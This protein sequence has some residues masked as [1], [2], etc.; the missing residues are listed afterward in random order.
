MRL[1]R[2]PESTLFRKVVLVKRRA[3][4]S[5]PNS[6]T[7]DNG[8]ETGPLW[9]NR[10]SR[11]GFMGCLG[12]VRRK[13]TIRRVIHLYA[14]RNKTGSPKGPRSQLPGLWVPGA[15]DLHHVLQHPSPNCPVGSPVRRPIGEPVPTA[16]QPPLLASHSRL[17]RSQRRSINAPT[18]LH[19]GTGLAA[20]TRHLMFGP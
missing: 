6:D 8:T 19:A 18:S 4:H 2:K 14:K 16:D 10:H 9:K 13:I 20:P 12:F 7:S 17:K 11:K 1:K 15:V 3:K 5:I